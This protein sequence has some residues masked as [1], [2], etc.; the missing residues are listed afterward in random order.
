M[1]H[2]KIDMK[3]RQ[4]WI[5]LLHRAAS[6]TRMS[7][8]L[9]TP[10]GMLIF[11]AFSSFFVLGGI[12]L[13]NLLD[14]S[15]LLPKVARL[16]V[17]V[18]IISFGMVLTFWSA[19]HFLKVKGTPVPF[20]PPPTLVCTGPYRYVRNPMLAGVFMILFGIG[21]FLNSTSLVLIFTPLYVISNVW[22]LKYIEEPEL[23]KRLGNVYSE[24]RR[25][26]PM[27]IPGRK[28]IN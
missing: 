14:F 6:G 24:Y 15:G 16:P 1:H 18:P 7:R 3:I 25:K 2:Q 5:Y 23:A 28:M 27:F 20:N 10:A 11:C 12:F 19:F 17:S 8:T 9:L 26:T 22:E 21:V 13:D 4:K